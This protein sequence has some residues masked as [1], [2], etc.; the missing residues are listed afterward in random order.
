MGKVKSLLLFFK[1][2]EKSGDWTEKSD[3]VREI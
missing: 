1:S 3:S 2:P